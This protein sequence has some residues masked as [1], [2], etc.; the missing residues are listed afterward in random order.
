MLKHHHLPGRQRNPGFVCG[1]RLGGDQADVPGAA[2]RNW[3][4][5][6]N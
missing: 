5:T 1:Q 3:N 6:P 4:L 2:L